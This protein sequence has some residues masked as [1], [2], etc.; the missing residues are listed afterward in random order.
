MFLCRYDRG[1]AA[2]LISSLAAG[3][4][5]TKEAGASRAHEYVALAL[6]DPRRAAALVERLPVT[7]DLSP[8]S[9]WARIRVAETLASSPGAR[10]KTIWRLH[11][12]LGGILFDRDYR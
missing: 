7:D 3:L 9:N 2:A 5:R 12:G 1:V 8:N 11:S 10:W 6:I 4:E